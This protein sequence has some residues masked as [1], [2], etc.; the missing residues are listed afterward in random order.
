MSYYEAVCPYCGQV[1]NIYS[2]DYEISSHAVGMIA[3]AQNPLD[4]LRKAA[5]AARWI[6]DN[7][8]RGADSLFDNTPIVEAKIEK[9]YNLSKGR[10]LYKC[11]QYTCPGCKKGISNELNK[12]VWCPGPS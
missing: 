5:N 2:R 12:E 11:I 9:E 8:R 10:V 4:D 3:G 1:F 7:W 6:F